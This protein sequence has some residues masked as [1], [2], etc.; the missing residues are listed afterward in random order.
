MIFPIIFI[1]IISVIVANNFSIK[2]EK[3]RLEEQCKY[4]SDIDS[5]AKNYQII[6][7]NCINNKET[8]NYYK[9]DVLKKFV[10]QTNDKILNLCYQPYEQVRL[11]AISIN[12]DNA[13]EFYISWDCFKGNIC[14]NIPLT[15]ATF[16][17]MDRNSK[18]WYPST[19]FT[20]GIIDKNTNVN[21]RIN[22]LTFKGGNKSVNILLNLSK[23]EF[24]KYRN[25]NKVSLVRKDEFN[26]ITENDKFNRFFDVYTDDLEKAKS[27][28]S[29]ELLE[30]IATF[31][32]KY[33]VDF[34]ISIN[35]KIYVRFFR[36]VPFLDRHSGRNI[37]FSE[38]NM[39]SKDGDKISAIQYYVV[40]KFIKEFV[41]K[42]K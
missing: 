2:K 19:A 13:T 10:N 8:I 23:E 7:D 20:I 33:K 15:I 9:D 12:I 38:N 36:S 18:G 32:M 4:I 27:F 11:N 41:E 34:E 21:I 16:W 40:T 17:Y 24:E 14:G 30:F 5:D 3:I 6:Y 1:L 35:D 29:S 25:M 37:M 39:V 42:I 28:L 22:N 26:Y 31:R